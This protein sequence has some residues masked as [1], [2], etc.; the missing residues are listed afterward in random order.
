MTLGT[1]LDT[2]G[3]SLLWSQLL[4]GQR[5]ALDRADARSHEYHRNMKEQWNNLS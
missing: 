1:R 4:I 2:Q 5:E 3:Y